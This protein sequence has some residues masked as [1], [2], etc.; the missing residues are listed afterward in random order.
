M[1][2]ILNFSVR[3]WLICATLG[4]IETRNIRSARSKEST[5]GKQPAVKMALISVEV[6]SDSVT[7]ALISV[8]RASISVKMAPIRVKIACFA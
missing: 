4:T 6:A 1:P 5:F 3:T 8:K 7:M 2:P